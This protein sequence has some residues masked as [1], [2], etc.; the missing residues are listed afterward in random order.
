MHRCAVLTVLGLG[1]P[2][3]LHPVDARVGLAG[4]HT[5]GALALRGRKVEQNVPHI[6]PTPSPEIR[7]S[8]WWVPGVGGCLGTTCLTEGRPSRPS[9]PSYSR[10]SPPSAPSYSSGNNAPSPTSLEAGDY[11]V[12]VDMDETANE[13]AVDSDVQ[14]QP[15]FAH[16]SGLSSSSSIAT[17]TS[18]TD[19]GNNG[20]AV[21]LAFGFI[22]AVVAIA[23]GAIGK[24]REKEKSEDAS[25]ASQTNSGAGSGDESDPQIIANDTAK[26]DSAEEEE[27]VT[28]A[29]MPDDTNTAESTVQPGTESGSGN[30]ASL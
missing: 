8:L 29:I 30:I 13:K 12:M 2:F 21:G 28:S 9:P 4:D 15:A 18:S 20:L 17:L 26:A 5:D 23:V 1:G 27:V 14:S 3:A 25:S 16:S 11:F 7:R 19:S 6:T 24:K 22:A 10:P